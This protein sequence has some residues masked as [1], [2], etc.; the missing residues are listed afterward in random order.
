MPEHSELLIAGLGVIFMLIGITGGGLKIKWLTV[1]RI[2][3]MAR[4]L[5]T[6]VGL[7]LTGWGLWNHHFDDAPDAHGIT[8]PINRIYA[9][10]FGANRGAGGRNL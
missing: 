9:E 2:D 7:A 10:E 3:R 1:P 5:L 4:I 6:V 8:E